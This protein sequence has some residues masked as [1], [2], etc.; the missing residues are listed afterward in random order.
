[1]TRKPLSNAAAIAVVTLIFFTWGG[2]TS[3]NDVLIPH[4][5]A[6]FDM[7]YARTMLIQSTFFGAYFLMSLPS[8]AVVARAGYR[9]SIAIGLVVAAVGAALFHPA[10]ALPSYPLFLGALFVLASGLT[11]L[12]VAANP[13]ISL[14]GDP[15]G[16]ASRMNLA[17]AL[18]SL[19]TTLF[20]WLIGPLI[21]STAVLGAGEIA[22]MNVAE[23]AAYR[24]QQAQSVQLP[25][26]LLGGGL[27][28]LAVFVLAMR[29]PTLRDAA[30]AVEKTRH[31]FTDA[32]RLRRVRWGA[33]AIFVY[34]GAE[35]A[36]GSFLINYI[37]GPDTGGL[38]E[39]TASRYL[40]LYWGGAM[41][42]RFAGAALLR[43]VDAR[44]LLAL[45]AVVAGLLLATTMGTRDQL[46]MWSVIA[47]GLF[48]S[49]MFPTIFAIA[50]ERLGP[51]TSRASSLLVM[52]IVGGAVVPWVQGWLADRIGIQHAFA[53]PLACYVFIVWYALRGSRHEADA[54]PVGDAEPLR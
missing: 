34:V 28:L 24:A 47:I 33:L 30:A 39:A 6:V 14:L 50:I 4:L 37:S 38:T 17:Q 7:N 2:L 54:E 46:A 52:A 26:L 41:V 3:L 51:L 21:L 13:Y 27:L 20:P 10:A 5:K 25:Y 40:A 19:G 49:I 16:A 1:M 32:L 36:I 43:R 9:G 22:A 23:Q 53:V 44:R 12:Q 15:A 8:G 45:F 42:G 18:N 31:G 11:L 35:V 29:L 48:N